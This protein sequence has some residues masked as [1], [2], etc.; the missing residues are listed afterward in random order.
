MRGRND[1]ISF[2]LPIGGGSVPQSFSD[3]SHLIVLET[4]GSVATAFAGVMLA[5][6]GAKVIVCE[7]PPHGSTIRQLG[8]P[9]VQSVW[10]KIIGRNKLSIA[11]DSSRAAAVP[12]I[13]RLCERADV[14]LCSRFNSETS[15]PWSDA[16]QSSVRPPLVVDIHTT[17]SDRPDL[18]PWSMRPELAAAATGIMALTGQKDGEPR[19]PEFPLT[20]YLCGMMAATHTLAELRRRSCTSTGLASLQIAE[21]EA[22]Q[23]MI[24]WQISVATALGRP[25]LRDGNNFSMAGGISYIHRTRDQHYVATSAATQSVAMR[26]MRMIGGDALCSDPRFVTPA[27]RSEHMPALI[28]IIDKWISEHSQ[29]EVLEAADAHD[30]VIGPIY[31]ANDV[32]HDAHLKARNNIIAIQDSGGRSLLMPNVLPRSSGIEASV[33]R[34]GPRIGA[35]TDEILQQLGFSPD[36]IQALSASGVIWK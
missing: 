25:E 35:D 3:L 14:L 13:E 2:G 17:G 1:N 31:E 18:W 20:E 29:D 21:H 24:E 16:S 30:V 10:W 6:F 19:Q 12:L 26:L 36:D 23:R 28:T 11:F 34:L 9:A 7:E 22:V 32:M 5:D 15:S 27:T 4:G 8:G 33:N